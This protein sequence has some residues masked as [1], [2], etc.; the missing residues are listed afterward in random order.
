[1]LKKQH[2]LQAFLTKESFIFMQT[3]DI[4]F[5]RAGGVGEIKSLSLY[6]WMLH[7]PER[8]HIGYKCVRAI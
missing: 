4:C 3:V 2:K 7:G 1:M 6:L 8:D 5:L